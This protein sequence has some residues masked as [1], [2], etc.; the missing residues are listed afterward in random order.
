MKKLI[1]IYVVCIG[2]MR[3]LHC[4]GASWTTLDA[5]GGDITHAYGIDGGNIVGNYSDATGIHGFLYDGTTWTTLDVP[6]GDYTIPEDIDGG[7]IVGTYWDATAIHG[8][9]YDGTTWTTLDAP[10]P[11]NTIPWGIDSVNIVGEYWNLTGF[12]SFLY[13]GTTWT[14]LDAP[15]ADSTHAHGID[16]GNI[17]GH[18]SDATGF[19]GFLYDGTTWTT[20]DAPG[21]DI[22]YAYD[23]DGGN[24]VG[25]Y[26]DATGQH[27]FLYDGTT[28]TN[29]DAPGGGITEAYGIDGGNIV[30]SYWNATG[31]HGFLYEI[32]EEPPC[33][34]PPSHDPW[35]FVQITDSHI[36][37]PGAREHLAC[38][39]DAITQL[40][41][42]PDFV[43]N[44]GDIVDSAWL[45]IT[46]ILWAREVYENYLEA[47]EPLDDYGIEHYEV[48]G[49][50]DRY[51]YGYV[52]PPILPW[53]WIPDYLYSQDLS[54]YSACLGGATDYSFES[55]GKSFIFYG[56]NSGKDVAEGVHIEP[57]VF[58]PTP[59]ELRGTGLTNEQM[60]E[61]YKLDMCKPKVIFMHHPVV[62]TEEGYV[63]ANNRDN[64][65]GFIEYCK[66]NNVQLVLTGHTHQYHILDADGTNIAPGSTQYPQFI[67]TPS[68]SDPKAWFISDPPGYRIVNVI[69]NKCRARAYTPLSPWDVLNTKLNSH[70]NVHVYD[71][72]SQHV[73]V[74]ASGSAERSIPRSFYFSPVA[75]DDGTKVLPEEIII[76]NPVDNYR[77]EVIGVET[78]TYRLNITFESGGEATTF[79]ATEITTGIAQVH[80]YIIDW[81]VLSAGNEG[82]I[83]EIDADGD[84][85]FERTVIAD[86]D[87]TSGEFTLQTETAI[88]FEPDTL[89]LRSP[90]K[91]V[92][93]YIEL[94]EGFDG[95][96]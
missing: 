34:P 66:T 93:V 96:F 43:L 11:Y 36:G 78:G 57:L 72:S 73:G 71:S 69:D 65:G 19:H 70:A 79:F 31:M 74:K 61:L 50:H 67:Q 64:P 68:V 59:E 51:V 6:G 44:T 82:V 13:D 26:L 94:P 83:L 81:Q 28:W 17:V 12:Y 2:L 95:R 8:F 77:H 29:L 3:P 58:P 18:Y 35:S 91:V 84:G 27:G 56:M 33:P 88:D 55:E 23:I 53:D 14:T 15:G 52:L 9:L 32:A 87:L 45:K 48:P 21:G 20:L 39:V 90:G 63:I 5:P 10:G 30:G 22:T 1:V 46:G 85:I 25:S 16:G 80:R 54:Q 86:E 75:T 40:D 4:I 24:I 49:N 60:E 42:K 62:H 76:F 38:A 41:P 47:M 37:F 92:T 89:N 7:N